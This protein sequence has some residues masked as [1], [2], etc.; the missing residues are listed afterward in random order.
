MEHIGS[1]WKQSSTERRQNRKFNQSFNRKIGH[2]NKRLNQMGQT[3]NL[4]MKDA[5]T[6]L[7]VDHVK[8]GGIVRPEVR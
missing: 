6:M 2:L 8:N 3:V 1:I 7:E 5:E 4:S